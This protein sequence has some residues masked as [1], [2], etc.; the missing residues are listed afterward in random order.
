VH[1]AVV[2]D[3][4]PGAEQPVELGQV[5]VVAVCELDVGV[6]GVSWLGP[7]VL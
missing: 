3:L 5:E 4:K 7:G 1:A 6:Q 2:D